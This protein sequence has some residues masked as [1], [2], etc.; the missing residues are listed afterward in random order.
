MVRIRFP[1]SSESATNSDV[2]DLVIVTCYA[3]IP[4]DGMDD[5]SESE[6]VHRCSPGSARPWGISIV[7]P[8]A[9][10]EGL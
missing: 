5:L 10:S 9:R 6:V 7:R 1:P 8:D 3:A 4:F 2:D